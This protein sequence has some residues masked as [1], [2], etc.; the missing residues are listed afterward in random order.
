MW[1]GN[2]SRDWKNNTT[3]TTATVHNMIRRTL[4]SNNLHLRVLVERASPSARTLSQ[5]APDV[6]AEVVA[7][8]VADVVVE[9]V[10]AVEVQELVVQV[11]L[12]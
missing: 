10:V 9:V 6:V 12:N 3:V 7:E 11:V 5:N 1:D 2:P 4:I 8:V